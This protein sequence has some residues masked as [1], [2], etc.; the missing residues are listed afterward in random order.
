[1][2]SAQ[3]ANE[4]FS[5]VLAGDT[6]TVIRLLH[7]CRGWYN[8]DGY[9]ALMLAGVQGNIKLI[10]ILMEHESSLLSKQEDMTALMLITIH[11]SVN[12]AKTLLEVEARRQN[13]RGLTALMLAC[14]NN[15]EDMIKLLSK[16]ETCCRTTLGETALMYLVRRNNYKCMHYVL[17]MEVKAQMNSGYS[18]LMMAAELGYYECAKLLANRE[19]CLQ[20]CEGETALMI[21]VR[22]GHVRI[23]R[24]LIKSEKRYQNSEGWTAL[25]LSIRY[26]MHRIATKLVDDEQ[27]IFSRNN[28]SALM[29][30]IYYEMPEITK[31]L[32]QK[33][34]GMVIRSIEETAAVVHHHLRPKHAQVITSHYLRKHGIVDVSLSSSKIPLSMAN[35]DLLS[36]RDISNDQ[37]LDSTFKPG[38]TAYMIA[39]LKKNFLVMELLHEHECGRQD[40]EGTSAAMLALE[41]MYTELCYRLNQIENGSDVES[42]Y[43]FICDGTWKHFLYAIDR[44]L[45]KE[46]RLQNNE[47]Q[48]LL[49]LAVNHGVGL[50]ERIRAL[51]RNIMLIRRLGRDTFFSLLNPNLS[52]QSVNTIFQ[53]QLGLIEDGVL[54]NAANQQIEDSGAHEY[55]VTMVE[56]ELTGSHVSVN[57]SFPM[58]ILDSDEE[59]IEESIRALKR[60]TRRRFAMNRTSKSQSEGTK[61]SIKNDQVSTSDNPSLKSEEDPKDENMEII[62]GTA[63]RAFTGYEARPSDTVLSARS[64]QIC[65]A[66]GKIISTRTG[67]PNN[68]V[69]FDDES[70]SDYLDETDYYKYEADTD[71]RIMLRDKIMRISSCF[72]KRHPEELD[73]ICTLAWTAH[74]ELIIT[75]AKWEARM[76]DIRGQTAL[77]YAVNHLHYSVVS[78]LASLEGSMQDNQGN[79]ALMHLILTA[80]RVSIKIEPI[81]AALH[82]ATSILQGKHG[83]EASYPKNTYVLYERSTIRQMMKILEILCPIEQGIHN[84]LGQ[85][86]LIFASA[87]GNFDAVRALLTVECTK[88]DNYGLSA[89][90]Y[91]IKSGNVNSALLLVPLEAHL[92]TWKKDTALMM[93]ARYG[94]LKICNEILK[95]ETS[96][97]RRQ[98]DDGYTAL[99]FAAKHGH[100][101]LVK[102]LHDYEFTK[103]DLLGQTAAIHAVLAGHIECVKLLVEE[104]DIVDNAGQTIGQIANKIGRAEIIE[105]LDFLFD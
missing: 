27:G 84:K 54:P 47:G 52:Q 29:L 85:T 22:K 92:V 99:I 78:I 45:P 35:I 6:G 26:Q 39:T 53:K 44:L 20:N 66:S 70:G 105:F 95:M 2:R 57:V 48:T 23:A 103:Q 86:A 31:V 19:H 61:L 81:Q 89:L 12:S 16:R 60:Q 56:H 55:S 10:R 69:Q 68:L 42:L 8:T 49:M 101:E 65:N 38:R 72:I 7:R 97:I 71:V 51:K 76:K 36:N 40:H 43:D 63:L 15:N 28:I 4:W 74:I 93:T 13:A 96:L 94:I 64:P 104:F 83:A 58:N 79:T 80:H 77:M 50:A 17:E 33:E 87:N 14:I 46:A 90:M 5:A 3:V 102:A 67:I 9:T 98:N 32:I 82:H 24:L 41:V 21:A 75:I 59:S 37:E 100:V 34:V 73:E 1:M 25:M 18:A 91:A 11:G 62:Q 88:Q 30:S